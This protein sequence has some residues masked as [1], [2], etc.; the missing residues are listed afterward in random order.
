M[1]E[2]SNDTVV[3]GKDDCADTQ[4][5]RDLLDRAAV[6]YTYHRVDVD[7]AAK[8]RAEA[9]SGVSRVPV[10]VVPSGAAL[11]EPSD[12]ELA[13]ALGLELEV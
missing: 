4:R 5:S 1:G 8:M 6:A 3:F 7:S 9:I 2:T 10:I 11:V 13:A 12:D